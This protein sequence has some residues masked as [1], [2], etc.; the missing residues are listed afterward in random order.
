MEE[1]SLEGVDVVVGS[2]IEL[3]GGP[4]EQATNA[5]TTTTSTTSTTPYFNAEGWAVY[6]G[7]SLTDEQCAAHAKRFHNAPGINFFFGNGTRGK[8]DSLLNTPGRTPPS[9]YRRPQFYGTN[10]DPTAVETSAT[11]VRQRNFWRDQDIQT[12]YYAEWDLPLP[13][14]LERKNYDEGRAWA[15][16]ARSGR[17]PNAADFIDHNSGKFPVAPAISLLFKIRF[18]A[19][20]KPKIIPKTAVGASSIV[21]SS[22]SGVGT[23]LAASLLTQ[24]KIK[25]PSMAPLSHLLGKITLDTASF[26]QRLKDSY[27]TSQN[28]LALFITT[29]DGQ[30][31]AAKDAASQFGVNEGGVL[32]PKRIWEVDGFQHITTKDFEFIAQ[33]GEEQC[34]DGPPPDRCKCRSKFI[35]ILREIEP[36]TS[37]SGFGSGFKPLDK[38]EDVLV[39]PVPNRLF[40][41]G[42]I[43]SG[44]DA[45]KPPLPDP[46][47]QWAE[48]GTD[49]FVAANIVEKDSATF[50]VVLKT[51]QSAF[52][53]TGVLLCAWFLILLAVFLRCG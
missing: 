13:H 37:L 28:H 42:R 26:M 38:G 20:E 22:F 8:I 24:Q 18:P 21:G 35:D 43:V 3:E 10:G 12:S 1:S 19:V 16:A 51:A 46:T 49:P 4:L 34:P 44:G 50:F 48:V 52:S 39:I 30:I 11:F 7:L 5:T 31:V 6:G 14:I 17:T 29:G 36:D 47:D 32:A 2:T 41:R 53:H 9:C 25:G 40:I 45:T 33:C 27:L 23:N 15:E